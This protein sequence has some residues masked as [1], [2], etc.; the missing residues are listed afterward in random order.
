[1]LKNVEVCFRKKFFKLQY[2]KQYTDF[3]SDGGFSLYCF[4]FFILVFFLILV[5]FG[6]VGPFRTS[7]TC[8]VQPVQSISYI[9]SCLVDGYLLYIAGGVVH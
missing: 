2:A 1:M 7:L 3:E 9:S 5:V 6:R 8:L 4:F